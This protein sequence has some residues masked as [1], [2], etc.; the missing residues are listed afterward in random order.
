MKGLAFLDLDGSVISSKRGCWG[1]D[2][3]PVELNGEGQPTSFINR[4][5]KALLE[6]L[7]AGFR[8]I[9]AT[10]RHVAGCRR[11]QLP[12]TD[13]AICSFGAVILTPA[14]EVEPT[15]HKLV[16]EHAQGER[17]NLNRMVELATATATS[18]GLHVQVDLMADA[19]LALY[20]NIKQVGP[21][22]GGLDRL[23]QAMR[24]HLPAGWWT[25]AN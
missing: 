14:G 8:L 12:F 13:Y 7:S 24:E 6:L 17:D 4:Q 10:A 1:D 20:V 15:W 16:S 18:L 9:P 11:I 23:A 21:T 3:E 5:Q 2:L 22:A 25:H 19:G